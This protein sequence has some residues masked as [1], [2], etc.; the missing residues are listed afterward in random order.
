M[1]AGILLKG[2]SVVVQDALKS[3]RSGK[4]PM[5]DAVR[6]QE[7]HHQRLINEFVLR[8]LR[9]AGAQFPIEANAQALVETAYLPDEVGS[10]DKG[11]R[12]H[13]RV[14]QD[15]LVK[16][17]LHHLAC[18]IRHVSGAALPEIQMIIAAVLD[19][20][21]VACAELGA[22]GSENGQLP[23]EERNEPLV[24]TVL[25]SEIGAAGL[26]NADIPGSSEPAIL[27]ESD[28]LEARV[29]NR[30]QIFGGVVGRP[31]VDNDQLEIFERLPENALDRPPDCR[32]AIIGRE[33][34]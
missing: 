23:L 22:R 3:E 24:V 18:Q 20:A 34:Y 11:L 31:I 4:P 5:A 9:E 17:S 33:D 15:F 29:R 14:P 19:L 2:G 1:Q 32:S 6:H 28:N 27:L 30:P 26:C 16:V 10:H 21:A 8:D 13:D 25:K 7:G 12:A